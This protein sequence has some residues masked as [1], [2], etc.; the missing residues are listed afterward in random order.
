MP[1]SIGPDAG[2]F[3]IKPATFHDVTYPPN[4]IG[5][6]RPVASELIYCQR[7]IRFVNTYG[8]EVA[9]QATTQGANVIVL[10]IRR[11]TVTRTLK[12]NMVMRWDGND[13][14]IVDIQA[15]PFNNRILRLVV[16]SRDTYE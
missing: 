16:K 1:V 11:D 15:K 13:Y 9:N 3:E 10:E 14:G 6:T 7:K 12:R 8:S 5:E 2:S 4:P